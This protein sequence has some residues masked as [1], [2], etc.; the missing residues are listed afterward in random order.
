[1]SVS[2]SIILVGGL[3]GSGGFIAGFLSRQPEINRLH[4]QVKQL[5]DENSALRKMLDEQKEKIEEQQNELRAY[6]FFNYI[7]KRQKKMALRRELIIQYA[8]KEYL[9]ILIEKDANRKNKD[10]KLSEEKEK[11]FDL[12][13][14]YIDNGDKGDDDKEEKLF[15]DQYVWDKYKEEIKSC[16]TWDYKESLKVA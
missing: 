16:K 4:K 6:K 8:M 11:F 9:E 15:L 14:K 1:M 2:I 7:K 10:Y 3:A 12:M 13:D 5:Q